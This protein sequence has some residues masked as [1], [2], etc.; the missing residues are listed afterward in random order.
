MALI[1]EKEAEFQ[2][3]FDA[4]AVAL[5]VVEQTADLER[6]PYEF[7]VNVT[8]VDSGE[9]CRMNRDFRGID[10]PTDVLSFPNLDFMA[11]GD[12]SLLEEE[13]READYFDMDSGLL[14]L[15]DI[16]INV[17]RVFSQAEEYGH[18]LKREYAFLI[19][20]SMLHLCGYDHMEPADAALMEEKQNRVLNALGITRDK[21]TWI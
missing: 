5:S 16:V 12:F 4:E 15:G 13:S 17:D 21:Q 11:P 3:D 7:D 6:I 10:Q 19:A 8:L 14:L 9:I 20:H 2:V 1:F 18:S